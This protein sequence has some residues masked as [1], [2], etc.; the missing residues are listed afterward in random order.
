[1]EDL[2]NKFENLFDK[3]KCT[4]FV[5]M[6]APVE[7]VSNNGV[8]K[9]KYRLSTHCIP[10]QSSYD[11][12]DSAFF[13]GFIVNK[14]L[15]ELYKELDLAPGRVFGLYKVEFSNDYVDPT[16]PSDIELK[17]LLRYDII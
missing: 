3:T 5:R 14:A 8:L 1:M 17:L 9:A 16:P 6:F 12:H 11:I 13:Q 2:T 15:E 7:G 4:K 10:Y